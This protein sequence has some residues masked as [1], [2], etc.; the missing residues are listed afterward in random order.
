MTPTQRRRIIWTQLTDKDAETLLSLS[1]R[2]VDAFKRYLAPTT[3]INA[4]IVL[5]AEIQALRAERH[6]L[7]A[8]YL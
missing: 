1:K 5:K 2:H 8:K 7:I 3:S 4:R 6:A